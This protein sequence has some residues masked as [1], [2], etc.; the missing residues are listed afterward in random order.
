MQLAIRR[1]CDDIMRD[2]P[3]GGQ[4]PKLPETCDLEVERD[5]IG[6][7]TR[8]LATAP[9]FEQDLTRLIVD[10]D[11]KLGFF[12]R[13]LKAARELRARMETAA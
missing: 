4:A 6:Q 10:I 12:A 5:L 7:A 13:S 1:D 8:K 2:L 11:Q 3:G 9:G